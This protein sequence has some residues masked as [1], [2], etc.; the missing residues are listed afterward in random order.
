[1]AGV[2]CASRVSKDLFI[3]RRQYESLLQLWEL[4]KHTDFVFIANVTC[5]WIASDWGLPIDERN[6]NVGW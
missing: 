6:F 5:L 3:Y 4:F 1:M 2:E